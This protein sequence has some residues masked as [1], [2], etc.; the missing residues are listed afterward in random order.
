MTLEPKKFRFSKIF[1]MLLFSNPCRFSSHFLNTVKLTVAST[2]FRL[3]VASTLADLRP[4]SLKIRKVR[5][6]EKIRDHIFHC[7]KLTQK[8][9]IL[10]FFAHAIFEKLQN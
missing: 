7:Q 1:T 2:I 10:T 8:N 3:R 9:E 6:S 4:N 5:I